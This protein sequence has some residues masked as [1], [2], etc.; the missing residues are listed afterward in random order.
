[1][2][3]SFSIEDKVKEEVSFVIIC[4]GEIVFQQQEHIVDSIQ[5]YRNHSLVLILKAN[6]YGRH[7][8]EETIQD[9]N[10]NTKHQ[11]VA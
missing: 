10:S 9:S 5:D 1:M 7:I 8:Y 4:F 6:V 2:T 11:N 3:V